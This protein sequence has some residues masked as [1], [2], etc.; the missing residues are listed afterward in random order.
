MAPAAFLW[1]FPRPRIPKVLI[2]GMGRGT[3]CPQWKTLMV[4]YW[5]G[6]KAS[7]VVSNAC[8]AQPSGW[9]REV[10]EFSDTSG[11]ALIP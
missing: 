10:G 5:G 1:G 6:K 4:G 8:R 9:W 7:C 11:V 2:K 3:E